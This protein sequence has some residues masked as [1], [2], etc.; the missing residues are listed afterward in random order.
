[1]AIKCE[2]SEYKG[3]P[4]LTITWDGREPDTRPLSLGISKCKK[5]LAAHD[6]IKD[7]VERHKNDPRRPR[8]QEAPKLERGQERSLESASERKATY[9]E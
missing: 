4:T 7:F 9:R 2:E 1:M 6:Q 5:V 8:P 3:Y